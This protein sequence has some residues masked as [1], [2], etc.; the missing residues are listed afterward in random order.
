ML[1]RLG[2]RGHGSISMVGAIYR[3]RHRCTSSSGTDG[4]CDQEGV[5][6]PEV[7]GRAM[8]GRLRLIAK[9]ALPARVACQTALVH[10]S[11]SPSTHSVPMRNYIGEVPRYRR[12]ITIGKFDPIA[13]AGRSIS[14]MIEPNPGDATMRFPINRIRKFGSSVI[15]FGSCGAPRPAEAL[16]WISELGSFRQ[17]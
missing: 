11:T 2:K 14:S 6:T 4:R 9:R 10:A 12:P 17:R 16:L 3:G 15:D 8:S 5:S 1:D 7:L 13:R